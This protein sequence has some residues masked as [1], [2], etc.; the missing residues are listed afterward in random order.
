MPRVEVRL[1]AVLSA[2]LI[3]LAGSV[4]PASAA[5]VEITPPGSA[6]T[7]STSDANVPPN[8]V[9]NNLATRWSGNG[10]GAWLTLDLGSTKTVGYVNVAV[11]QGNMRAN[12]F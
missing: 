7:A 10:D 2:A 9:D 1:R 6:V 5:Y 12:R 4:A 11:Y 8:V 3:L